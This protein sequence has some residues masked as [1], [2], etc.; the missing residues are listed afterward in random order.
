[1]LARVVSKRLPRG[2]GVRVRARDR[3]RVRVRA[4]L[5]SKGLF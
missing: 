4:F 1:M 5:T 2:Q 3:V